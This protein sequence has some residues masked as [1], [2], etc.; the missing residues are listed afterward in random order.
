M[1][2]Y[3]FEIDGDNNDYADCF[4]NVFAKNL[5]EAFKQ[6]NE[7]DGRYVKRYWVVREFNI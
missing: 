4:H 7:T 1:I 6:W 2:Q 3:R 5:K